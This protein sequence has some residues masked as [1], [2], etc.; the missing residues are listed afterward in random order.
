MEIANVKGQVDFGIITIREDEFEAVLDRFPEDLGIVSG[1]RQYNLRRI[2]PGDPYTIAIVR[3]AI[4][5]NSEAQQVANALLDDLRPRW[6]LVVGIAGG[7][8]ASEFT[9]GDVVVATEVCDFNVGAVLKD[10]SHEYALHGWMSHPEVAKLA[11]NLPAM[12]TQLGAWNSRE[13]VHCSRPAIQVLPALLYGN[14]D[15]KKRLKKILEHHAAERRQKPRVTTGAIACSDLV[16]K[17]AELFQVCL[18]FARQVIAVEMESAGV[19]KAAQERHVPF[20]SI[21]ALSDIV[22]FSRDPKWTAY[23]CHTAAAFTRAFLLTRPIEPRHPSQYDLAAGTGDPDVS[24]LLEILGARNWHS[25]I[26]VEDSV[27]AQLAQTQSSLKFM[28]FGFHRYVLYDENSSDRPLTAAIERCHDIGAPESIPVKILVMNP[29]SPRIEEYSDEALSPGRGKLVQ[30]RILDTLKYIE[31]FR[32]RGFN[33]QV[34]FYPDSL[35]AKASFRMYI[36][37]DKTAYV[38]YYK[39]RYGHASD[40]GHFSEVQIERGK[41]DGF[42][43]PFHSLFNYLWDVGEIADSG[44]L[45]FPLKTSELTSRSSGWLRKNLEVVCHPRPLDL[46]KAV[47]AAVAGKDSMAAIVDVASRDDVNL[48]VPLVVKVPTEQDDWRVRLTT[49]HT[50]RK[51]LTARGIDAH[52]TPPIVLDDDKGIW[53]STNSDWQEQLRDAA[54][55]PCV[56]CHFYIHAIRCKV[57][58]LLGITRVIEGARERHGVDIKLNQTAAALDHFVEFA[59]ATYGVRLQFPLRY[60]VD[61]EA[62]WRRLE[63]IERSQIRDLPCIFSGKGTVTELPGEL[64]NRLREYTED[65]ASNNYKRAAENE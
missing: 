37:N 62:V 44:S 13:S 34:R 3:C 24:A 64:R 31:G 28:G 23:A 22:G 58:K 41:S 32:E 52:V 9:L 56:G 5:A 25:S 18:K 46:E 29:F 59:K 50:L 14:A 19:H 27:R 55:S 30:I 40:D 10:G 47:V 26:N 45:Y 33:V 7:A 48:I 8:P 4:Q 36:A 2:A 60:E 35:A 17:D 12:R 53:R 38:S 11:A 54:Q 16:M 65:V 1:R 20:M 15:W 21:R 42:F 61:D 57:A 63:G 51:V 43:L 6:L 49:L 39:A